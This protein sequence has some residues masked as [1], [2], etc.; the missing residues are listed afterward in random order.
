MSEKKRKRHEEMP[1]KRTS[2]KI[3]TV[4]PSQTIKVSVIEDRDEW[5]PILGECS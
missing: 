5:V 4:S 2:K 3:A 1:D